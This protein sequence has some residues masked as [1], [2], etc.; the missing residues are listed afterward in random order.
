MI[1]AGLISS[2]SLRG[3]LAGKQ[4]SR[5]MVCHKTMLEALERLLINVYLAERGK[6]NV[7]EFLGEQSQ[8]IIQDALETPSKLIVERAMKDDE[9]HALVVG[10]AEFKDEVRGG[11]LGKTAELWLSYMDHI[12]LILKLIQAVKTNNFVLYCECFYSMS[13][14]F[15]SFGGQNYSRY[16]T[17]F[18]VFLAN[19]EETHPGATQLL[20]GG[21]F[22]VA[23]SLIPGN[24]CAVDKTIEETFMKHA[25]SHGGAGGCGAGLTGLVNN[26]NSYQRWVRTTH[27]RA[28]FVD[29]TFSLADM[30]SESVGDRKHKDLRPAEVNKGEKKVRRAIE[31]VNSFI[32]PF[33][34]P[35]KNKLYSLSSGAAAPP[36]VMKDVLRADRAGTE[37][38]EKFIR[39]PVKRLKLLT[40]GNTCKSVLLKTSKNKL[41]EYKQQGSMALQLLVKSQEGNIVGLEDIMKYSL[42]PVPYSLGTADGYLAITPK[43]KGFHYLTKEVNDATIPPPDVT[44]LIV[45][46]NALFY[47]MRELPNNFKEICY[48][49]FD[50]L[51]KSSDIIFST[52]M[53]NEN[54]IK[55]LERQRRGC[56]NKLI[57][58]GELTKKPVDWKVFLTNDENKKQF[59]QVILKVWSTNEFAPQLKTRNVIAISEGHAFLLQTDDGRITKKTEICPLFSTQEETDTRVILYCKYAQDQGYDYARIRTP[60][61]DIFFILLHYVASFNITILFDTGSG[62]N[63][64]LINVTELADGL[65]P[66][67]CT[68]LL[69][70]HAFTHCDTTSAFKGIGKIKPIKVLQKL[71]KFQP[72]LA[73]LGREWEIT[74]ELFVGLEEFTCAIYGRPRF[75]SIDKLRFSLIKEKCGDDDRLHLGRNVDLATLPPCRGVLQQ[76]IR[77]VNYQVAIWRQAHIAVI[78]VPSPTDGHGWTLKSGHLEPL[79]VDGPILPEVVADEVEGLH[80]SDS[81]DEQSDDQESPII[82]DDSEDDDY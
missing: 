53:Y 69:A 49:V 73:E 40:L 50:T 79:W 24:R 12:W 61:S 54:S 13:G 29:A 6:D 57:I 55:A 43:A 75:K 77:R 63:K 36:D 3:V 60:D 31:A 21:A 52:D 14:L 5:A 16:L 20:K 15:F 37:A 33:D 82:S 22:S 46:G 56:S 25:K 17:F 39:E 19:V 71:P 42:T 41:V 26:Y 30:L 34:V 72:I 10:Y 62:N 47:C 44:V 59:V 81:E 18:S 11:K 2:G 4:Y 23:R 70:L 28:Q 9:I 35:I 27:E 67:Y 76:H 68:A 78:D 58:R 38:K 1:E 32:N 8:L 51:P 45:D 66:E 64:R 7:M 65:T 48:K 74:E 80:S